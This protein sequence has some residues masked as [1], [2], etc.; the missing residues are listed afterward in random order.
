MVLPPVSSCASVRC[1]SLH[2][3]AGFPL[4]AAG[5]SG[6]KPLLTLCSVAALLPQTGLRSRISGLLDRLSFFQALHWPR[7]TA[8]LEDTRHIPAPRSLLC[9]LPL[10]GC[11]SPRYPGASLA[12]ASG[13]RCHL[14][15]EAF[16]DRS[17]GVSQPSNPHPLSLGYFVALGLITVPNAMHG[18]DL[19]GPL[20]ASPLS[21]SG[22][23]LCL[24]CLV[25]Q[26]VPGT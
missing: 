23:G 3:S 21:T 7:R 19:A 25:A 15:S 22:Q 11:S 24:F 20:P 26:P 16:P 13:F 17:D 2:A 14:L 4:W 1:E 10:P 9:L 6:Q 8:L 18:I 5:H 12:P